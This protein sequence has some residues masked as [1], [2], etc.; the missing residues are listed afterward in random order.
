MSG[1]SNFLNKKE[2]IMQKKNNLINEYK[3][4]VKNHRRSGTGFS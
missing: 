1:K 4:G 2:K 3:F